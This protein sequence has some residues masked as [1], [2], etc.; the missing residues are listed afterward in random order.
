MRDREPESASF[1]HNYWVL[2]SRAE[3]LSKQEESVIDEPVPRVEQAMQAYRVCRDRLDWVKET[4]GQ[5]FRGD[6]PLAGDGRPSP[7]LDGVIATSRLAWSG[8]ECDG[9]GSR[10]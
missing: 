9:D 4:L 5:Y 7:G 8:R 1:K 2:N 3:W 6:G 10:F